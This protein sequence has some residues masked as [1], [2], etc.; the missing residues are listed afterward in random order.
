MFKVIDLA[1][2]KNLRNRTGIGIME[3]KK[4]LIESNGNIELAIDIMRKSGQIKALKKSI[5]TATEGIIITHLNKKFGMIIEINCQTDF[6][7]KDSCFKNF[8]NKVLNT[9]IEESIFSIDLLK[10]KFENERIALINKTGENIEIRRI[11]MLTGDS[12]EKYQHGTRIGVI[13]SARGNVDQKLAKNIA[14]HIAAS[15]PEYLNI[16]DIPTE[17]INHEYEIQLSIALK[18]GKQGK[19]AEKVVDGRMNKF[20]KSISLMNQSFILEPEKTVGQL[21]KENKIYINNFVRFE[22]GESIKN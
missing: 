1:L 4:A 5:N 18:A 14:M 13:I 22:L 20:V 21:T 9:A 6:V 19:I 3:C 16:Q 15:K 7:A 10:S 12:L 8:T 11:S 17:I 2:V